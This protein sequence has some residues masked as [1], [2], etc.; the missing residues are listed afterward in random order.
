MYTILKFSHY[1]LR[2]IIFLK[3]DWG[4]LKVHIVNPRS[5]TRGKKQRDKL[6]METKQNSKNAPL[7]KKKAEKE[8]KMR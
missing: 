8:E 5:V 4:K 1:T 6:I 2:G 7:T 3:A